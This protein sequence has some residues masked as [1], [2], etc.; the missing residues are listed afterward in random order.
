VSGKR[1][2]LDS[3]IIIYLSKNEMDFSCLEEFDDLYISVI[4]YMEILGYAFPTNE[5]ENFIKEL[6]SFFDI[7]FIDR[8]IADLTIDIRKTKRI[9]LPDAII[10][11]TAIAGE[12]NL[13]TR[14][15]DDFTNLNVKIVNPFE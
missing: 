12:L 9:K 11:A 1:A 15:V 3:N 7:I 5:E 14:D 2:L 4:T 6:L 8:R 13:I 10:S